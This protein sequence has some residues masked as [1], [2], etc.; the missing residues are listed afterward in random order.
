MHDFYC[1]TY[2]FFLLKIIGYWFAGYNETY[3]MYDS[4]SIG[5]SRIKRICSYYNNII[6]QLFS[7][8]Q[9]CT[10]YEILVQQKVKSK[11]LY[12]VQIRYICYRSSS[13]TK[14]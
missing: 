11:Y 14:T 8:F 7:L 5:F 3:L 6:Q 9:V 4:K 13:G 2:Y 1:I 12:V 10:L